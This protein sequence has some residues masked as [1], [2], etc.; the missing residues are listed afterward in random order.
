MLS[1]RVIKLM[2][3]KDAFLVVEAFMSTANAPAS[4]TPDQ[5]KK[6][7]LA[8]DSFDNLIKMAKKHKLKIA[9]GSDLFLSKEM[10]DF[11]SQEWVA[12]S[13]YFTPVE[14]LMQATSIGAE[15]IELSGPRNRYQEGPLGVIKKGAY[16]DILLIEGDVMNDITVLADPVNNIDLIMKDGVIYK[17]SL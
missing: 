2:A 8:K 16:A 3:E 5:R 9:F 11:Q 7:Q 14:N 10:Y 1:E 12:R 15:L 17:N 6:F 4:F 13:K